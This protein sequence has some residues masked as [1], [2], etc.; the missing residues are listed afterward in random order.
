MLVRTL[1]GKGTG[2]GVCVCVRPIAVASLGTLERK[3]PP[4]R[5]LDEEGLNAPHSHTHAHTRVDFQ[6]TIPPSLVTGN[7]FVFI[8]YPTLIIE[9]LGNHQFPDPIHHCRGSFPYI[10]KEPPTGLVMMVVRMYF[11]GT[12][13]RGE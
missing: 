10:L 12:N 8:K 4:N 1:F 6:A 3:H 9:T 7:A 2:H 5:M 13:S 11:D